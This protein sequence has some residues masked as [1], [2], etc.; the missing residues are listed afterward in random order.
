MITTQAFLS[1]KFLNDLMGQFLKFIYSI[2]GDYGIS[3]IIITIIVRLILF[4]LTIKQEKSMLRMK[5]IQPKI[6]EIKKKHGNDKAKINELTAKL[7]QEEKVNP[8]GGCLPLLIQLPVFIA[9]YQTIMSGI[10][11]KETPFLWFKLGYPDALFTVFGFDINLL[12]ILSTILMIFQQQFMVTNSDD[13]TAKSMQTMMYVMPVLMMFIFYKLPSG[14]NLYY[15]FN[16]LLSIL[17]QQYVIRNVRKN[18]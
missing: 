2:V 1:F 15:T 13:E 18:E 5:E 8:L 10:I 7:M 4:P 17:Q 6:D 9:I 14:L 12:P 11:P 16:T 3:I